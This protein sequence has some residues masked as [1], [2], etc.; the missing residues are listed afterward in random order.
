MRGSGDKWVLVL[1]FLVLLVGGY[2]VAKPDKPFESDISS[3]SNGNEGIL[4]AS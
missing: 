3:R 1:I 4:Y 2:L